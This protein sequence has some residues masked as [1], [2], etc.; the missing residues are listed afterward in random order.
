MEG[1]KKMETRKN[2]K[3]LLFSLFVIFV[4]FVVKGLY[5]I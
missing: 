2:E 4:S 3:I 5:G 1:K